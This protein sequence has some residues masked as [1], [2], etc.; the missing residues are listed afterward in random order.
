MKTQT[1]PQ[2]QNL[3]TFSL[4]GLILMTF[5]AFNLSYGQ[6]ATTP[7]KKI[8]TNERTIKGVVSDETETLLGVNIV[9]EGTTTGTTTNEKGEFT[10]PK[11]LK[12][13]DI[14]LFSYLGYET[15]KVEIK[16]DTTFINLKL[17][18]DSVTMIGALDSG[19]PYKSK[20]K[21]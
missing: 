4:I 16:D 20:R 21:D 14:L 1:L 12:T 6:I 7:T 10:F 9:L 11:K 13:G 17:T 19:K 18:I 3:K 15:Q 8:T 2:T 5:F